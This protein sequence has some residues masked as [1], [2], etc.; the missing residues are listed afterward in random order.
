M[1]N[2]PTRPEVGELFLDFRGMGKYL[3]DLPAGATF[4]MRGEKE[5]FSEVRSELLRNQSD[6]G[7]RAGITAQE[8]EALEQSTS[9]INEI[10]QND[11]VIRKISEMFRE[12]RAKEADERE[13]LLSRLA[14]KVELYVRHNN[15]P[16]LLAKYEQLL[17][18]R[19]QTAR[20]S[21]ETRR[22]NA[23]TAAELEQSETLKKTKEAL[24]AVFSARSLTVSEAQRQQLQEAKDLEQLSRWLL[25]ATIAP[26]V[27]DALA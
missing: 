7:E 21:A 19:S 9:R 18:Y 27:Q 24:F 22:R 12:T 16:E 13:K 17:A 4:R 26:S 3:L 23:E 6:F 5:G 2:D 10:D 11:K 25:R 15:D 20:K 8:I 14:E 1:A